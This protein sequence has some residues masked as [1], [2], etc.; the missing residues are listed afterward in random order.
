[1]EEDQ[2][3]SQE[4]EAGIEVQEDKENQSTDQDTANEDKAESSTERRAAQEPTTQ[5][6]GNH[7]QA[8][9]SSP[10]GESLHH[11]HGML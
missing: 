2:L 1:M 4:A 3:R 8:V 10:A 11:K 7:E 9:S 6:K 5:T